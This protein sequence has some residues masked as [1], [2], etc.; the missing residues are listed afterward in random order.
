MNHFRSCWNLLELLLVSALLGCCGSAW[1]QA[2]KPWSENP[3]YWSHDGEPILLLGGS[4]D[5]NLFQWPEER[6]IA[7]LDR[8]VAAIGKPRRRA[9]WV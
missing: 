8:I 5:D 3:W 1:G 6:L 7:Q 9:R 4:E 2:L